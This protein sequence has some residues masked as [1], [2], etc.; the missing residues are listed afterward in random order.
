[1]IVGGIIYA[2]RTANIVIGLFCTYFTPIHA[3]IIVEV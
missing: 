3:V 1:M 2:I